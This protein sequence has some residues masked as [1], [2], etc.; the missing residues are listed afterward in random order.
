MPKRCQFL[1][2]ATCSAGCVK[3]GA[4][5]LALGGGHHPCVMD[6]E[7]VPVPVLPHRTRPLHMS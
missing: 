3:Q 5:V 4:V 6:T 1:T 2:K 7:P